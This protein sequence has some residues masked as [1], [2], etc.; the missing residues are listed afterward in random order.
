MLFFPN[1]A[2]CSDRQVMSIEN[3]L[4]LCDPRELCSEVLRVFVDT[5]A[6]LGE[7]LFDVAALNLEPP[8]LTFETRELASC[9]RI[10]HDFRS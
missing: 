7:E 1:P 4:D 3:R 2:A 6:Q 8:M 5:I 10:P 9:R